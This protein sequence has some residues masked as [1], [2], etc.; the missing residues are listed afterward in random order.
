VTVPDRD[1]KFTQ[2]TTDQDGY[3]YGL[4]TYGRVW[5]TY[6]PSHKESR[7]TIVKGPK[8]SDAANQ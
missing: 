1:I 2:I 5:R 4:D 8:E 7:W 6:R 3:L